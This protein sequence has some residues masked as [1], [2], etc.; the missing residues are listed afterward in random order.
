MEVEKQWKS[1]KECLSSSST[2]P[3]RYSHVGRAAQVTSSTLLA[4]GPHDCKPQP[5]HVL[6]QHKITTRKKR[7]GEE[8]RTTGCAV[9]GA[10]EVGR[11]QSGCG[12]SAGAGGTLHPN[13]CI[14]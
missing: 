8:I 1:F 2:T 5:Q 7:V 3:M 10:R 6:N 12:H 4:A 9:G 14:R 11:R 13:H